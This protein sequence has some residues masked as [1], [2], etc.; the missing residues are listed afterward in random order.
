MKVVPSPLVG[1]IS[2]G[3]D[4][5]AKWNTNVTF[6]G[7]SFVMDPDIGPDDWTGFTWK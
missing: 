5:V 7:K 2:G 6:D 4:R 3:P 1:E